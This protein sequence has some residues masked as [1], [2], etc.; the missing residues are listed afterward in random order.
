MPK[1][2]RQ[3]SLVKELS[4]AAQNGIGTIYVL[5]DLGRDIGLDVLSADP[6]D[7]VDDMVKEMDSIFKRYD[8]ARSIP[9]NYKSIVLMF[10]EILDGAKNYCFQSEEQYAGLEFMA[11]LAIETAH[12]TAFNAVSQP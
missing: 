9:A 2:P 1:E 7:R 8:G 10:R 4:A 6:A 3:L 11:S 5:K 12:F